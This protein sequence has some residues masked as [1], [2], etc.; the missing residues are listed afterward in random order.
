MGEGRREERDEGRKR[1]RDEGRKE[2]VIEL[3][4]FLEGN[5]ERKIGISKAS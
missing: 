4:C 1:G 3:V 2:G 5:T